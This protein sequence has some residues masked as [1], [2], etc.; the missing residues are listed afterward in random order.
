V[1]TINVKWCIWR[2][3][4]VNVSDT[5]E[6]LKTVSDKLFRSGWL[7]TVQYFSGVTL[8]GFGV[9]KY[10]TGECLKC[11]V[12]SMVWPIFFVRNL[13]FI[14]LMFI[15]QENYESFTKAVEIWLWQNNN[16]SKIDLLLH[17][18]WSKLLLFNAFVVVVVVVV[19]TAVHVTFFDDVKLSILY[20][21]LI[22][23]RK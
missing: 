4:K 12:F 20:Q 22:T 9:H 10:V 14:C 16:L 8:S 17:L 2:R 15:R 3:L 23:K 5:T 18:C 13:M 6:C 7:W 1:S 21:Q 11:R 19:V